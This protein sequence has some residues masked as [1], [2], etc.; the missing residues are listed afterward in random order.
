MNFLEDNVRHCRSRCLFV[1]HV[2]IEVANY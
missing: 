1:M 2:L